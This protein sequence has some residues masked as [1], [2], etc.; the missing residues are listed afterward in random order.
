MFINIYGILKNLYW[1]FK[2]IEKLNLFGLKILFEN[3][4]LSI[5]LCGKNFIVIFCGWVEFFIEIKF[6]IELLLGFY[7]F[8]DI[9]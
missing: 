7:Y 9:V 8:N 6:M 1:S 3:Y 2:F 4:L 5:I